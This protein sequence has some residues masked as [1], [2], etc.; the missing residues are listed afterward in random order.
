MPCNKFD[1]EVK[2][3]SCRWPVQHPSSCRVC[4]CAKKEL[5]RRRLQNSGPQAQPHFNSFPC[6]SCSGHCHVNTTKQASDISSD[7]HVVKLSQC[8]RDHDGS[9]DGRHWRWQVY[10][11]CESSLWTGYVKV[12]VKISRHQTSSPLSTPA[13]LW[14]LFPLR[15]WYHRYT[16]SVSQLQSNS[17]SA[18]VWFLFHPR[19]WYHR[20]SDCYSPIA[21]LHLSDSSSSSGSDTMDTQ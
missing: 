9:K 15:K 4:S 7:N 13:L 5:R 12:Q 16:A 20:V 1:R 2:M 3:A 11:H 18:L 8:S 21:P 10:S 14:F 17:T 6:P 19:K